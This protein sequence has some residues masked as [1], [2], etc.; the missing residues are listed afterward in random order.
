MLF[1][2]ETNEVWFGNL[3]SFLPPKHRLATP[4]LSF[5]G[6]KDVQYP[7]GLMFRNGKAI[8]AIEFQDRCPTWLHIDFLDFCRALPATPQRL[9]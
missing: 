5:N 4:P 9:Y 8:L 6:T 3:I 7:Y 2:A 1:D